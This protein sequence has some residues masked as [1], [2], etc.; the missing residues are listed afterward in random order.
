[1]VVLLDVAGGEGVHAGGCGV[2]RSILSVDSEGLRV[3]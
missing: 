1:M 2:I 3:V